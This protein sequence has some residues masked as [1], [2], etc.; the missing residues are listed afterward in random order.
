MIEIPLLL[1]G[2]A[3]NVIELLRYLLCD[4]VEDELGSGFGAHYVATAAYR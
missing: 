2:H 1:V 4:E 3:I